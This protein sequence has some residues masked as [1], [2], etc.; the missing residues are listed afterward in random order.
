[1]LKMVAI[2]AY[3]SILIRPGGLSRGLPIPLGR[4]RSLVTTPDVMNGVRV[5]PRWLQG[6]MAGPL[7]R[8]QRVSTIA[9][10]VRIP[11]EVFIRCFI[12]TAPLRGTRGDALRIS[13]RRARNKRSPTRPNLR[14]LLDTLVYKTNRHF[15]LPPWLWPRYQNS[16]KPLA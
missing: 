16:S 10:C 4:A 12:L 3:Y 11:S 5:S 14:N 13:I 7:L 1:M 6:L 9:E 15:P 2:V 8:L